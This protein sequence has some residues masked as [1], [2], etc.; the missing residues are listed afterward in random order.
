MANKRKKTSAKETKPKKHARLTRIKTN[1]NYLTVEDE[2]KQVAA[3][4][5]TRVYN[6]KKIQ[7]IKTK[8]Q[9]M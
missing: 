8:H 3:N 4:H 1:A 6:W 5:S 2:Q 7:K 9:T